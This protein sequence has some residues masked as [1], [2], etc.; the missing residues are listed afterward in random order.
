MRLPLLCILSLL[1]TCVGVSAAPAQPGDEWLVTTMGSVIRP[2]ATW[3]QIKSHMFMVFY[4]SNPDERGVSAEGV[5]N[6]RRIAMAQQRAQA[7]A[8]ILTYDLNG[9]GIVTKDEI[10]TV[11]QPRARQMINANGVQLEPTPQQTRLQLDKLVG[12]ALKPDTNGDGTISVEEIQQSA[13]RQADAFGLG[14]QQNAGRF[15]PMTLDA[16][17]D[18]AV[19]IVEYEAAVRAHF[20]SV[21][22]D[23]DARISASEF[24][25]FSERLKEARQA[26]QREREAQIRKQRFEM[27]ATACEVAPAPPGARLV[28]LGAHNAKALSNAWIGSED[29]VTYVTTVEIAPGRDPLYLALTS[30]TAMLWDIVGATERIAGVVAHSEATLDNTGDGLGRQ[31][32]AANRPAGLQPGG[33]PLVGVIGV[34][35][36]KVRFTAHKGCLVPVTE[37]TMKDGS[38]QDMAALLLGRA[39][40]E[41]GGETSAGTF[42]VPP[43]MHFRD[44]PVRN[45]M[46]LP[47]GILGEVLWREVEEKLSAG[48]AQIDLESVISAHPVKRYDVLPDRAG[49]AALVDVGA[50]EIVGYSRGIH[51]NGGDFKPFTSPDRFKITQKLRLPAGTVGTF[52]LPSEVP[53]PEGDLSQVCLLSAADMKP[54]SGAPR[55]RC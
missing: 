33:K 51:I 36:D 42:R 31:V 1:A 23:R 38:A 32:A 25:E 12:D 11:M 54:L 30:G 47:K 29:R 15:V 14:W 46:Q 45:A 10:A 41:I 48:I 6:L 44:R 37:T 27:A 17:G 8:Q 39:A 4:Q 24:G 35:R 40:D 2:D 20:D 52:I 43:V 49:L 3:E 5:E 19:S 55:G 34:P 18:G 22:K 16:N 50:L 13:Q 26:A 53:V 9:D 7:V 21:D 28:L